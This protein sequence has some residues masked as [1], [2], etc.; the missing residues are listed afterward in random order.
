MYTFL[1]RPEFIKAP[2]FRKQKETAVQIHT[3]FA[4]EATRFKS[5]NIR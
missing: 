1:H 4:S 3:H 2:D 5:L